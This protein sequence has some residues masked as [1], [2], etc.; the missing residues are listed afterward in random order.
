MRKKSKHN[1][2]ES[3]QT[4]VKE[5]KKKGIEELQK[6]QKIKRKESMPNTKEIHHQ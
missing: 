3:H 2:I 1:T 4:T 6:S 5:R